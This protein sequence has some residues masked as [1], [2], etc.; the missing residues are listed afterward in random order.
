MGLADEYLAALQALLPHGAAWPRQPEAVLTKTLQALADDMALLDERAGALLEECDLRTAYELLLDWETAASLPDVVYSAAQTVIER[1][2]ALESKL[3][4][5]GGQSKPALI[6]LAAKLGYDITIT[7]F[8]PF[9][10]N[11]PVT[12]PVQDAIWRFLW[13]INSPDVTVSDATCQSPCVDP[14]RSWGEE[15]LE[16]VFRKYKAAHTEVQFAYGG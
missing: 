3:T 12:D 5:I 14:L 10:V 11:S 2:Q 9:T 16:A 6:A 13:Q 4:G 1:R 8:R 15:R 7:E